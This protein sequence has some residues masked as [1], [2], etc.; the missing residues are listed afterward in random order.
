VVIDI[1]NISRASAFK[2][3]YDPPVG[4]NSDTPE[5]GEIAPQRV[6]SKPNDIHVLR[7]GRRI[8]TRQDPCDFRDMLRV[9]PTAVIVLVEPTQTAMPEPRNHDGMYGDNRRLST[10]AAEASGYSDMPVGVSRTSMAIS[11]GGR[12]EL[13]VRFGNNP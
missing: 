1:I 12:R 3:K 11:S 10:P 13:S 2:T 5:S 9:Q 7:P 6:Q 8:Q 4:A